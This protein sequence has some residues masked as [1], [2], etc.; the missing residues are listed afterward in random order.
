LVT[1]IAIWHSRPGCEDQVEQLLKAMRARTR[2][3]PGCLRYELHRMRDEPRRFVLCEVYADDASIAAH[4]RTEHYRSLVR[5][6]APELV[7]RREV[8]RCD[9]LD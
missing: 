7:E 2:L 4:H 6:R 3:E 9:P 1:V 5:D 8:L